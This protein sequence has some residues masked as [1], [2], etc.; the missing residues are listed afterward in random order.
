MFYSIYLRLGID[1]MTKIHPAEEPTKHEEELPET[2]HDDTNMDLQ[3]TDMIKV[4]FLACS[5]NAIVQTA[6]FYPSGFL[7]NY[8]HDNSLDLTFGTI[9]VAT[10]MVTS[11]LAFLIIP[12]LPARYRN[13]SLPF[14]CVLHCLVNSICCALVALLDPALKFDRSGNTGFAILLLLRAIQGNNDNN[15][16][17]ET[18]PFRISQNPSFSELFSTQ[19][20]FKIKYYYCF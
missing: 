5:G 20:Q 7:V 8:I 11:A 19:F 14:R 18:Q 13:S 16:I 3:I 1:T 2:P 4:M 10:V 17:I 12:I 9:A 6:K 15:D